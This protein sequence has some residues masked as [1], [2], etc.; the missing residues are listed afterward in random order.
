MPRVLLLI[1]SADTG[2]FALQRAVFGDLLSE[3]PRKTALDK[4]ALW[5]KKHEDS[6][7]TVREALF[8]RESV[9]L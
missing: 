3:H 4:S 2:A 1:Y 6:F 5:D 9:P 7:L 8:G